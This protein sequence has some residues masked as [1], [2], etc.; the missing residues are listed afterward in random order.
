MTSQGQ[1]YLTFA[2]FESILITRRLQ[3]YR[4]LH[5]RQAGELDDYILR[6]LLSVLVVREQ[7]Y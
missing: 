4:S 6:E 7:V 2:V 5:L 3:W 1:F